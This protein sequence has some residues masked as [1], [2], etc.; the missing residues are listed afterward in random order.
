[1]SSIGTQMA[2]R[3]SQR[4]G[5]N[6]GGEKVEKRFG[7]QNA[8][9]AGHPFAHGAENPG[10]AGAEQN[11]NRDIA[12]NKGLFNCAFFARWREHCWLTDQRIDAFFHIAGFAEQRADQREST[13]T[14]RLA[15][16]TPACRCPMTPDQK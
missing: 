2:R 12:L 16:F 9:V 6:G 15:H 11:D 4:A 8:G 7:N 10:A 14:G 13:I 3:Q 5:E 1:M